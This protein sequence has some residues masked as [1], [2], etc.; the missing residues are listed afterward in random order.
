MSKYTTELRYIVEQALDDV[1][2]S[3]TE[4]NWP[5]CYAA[6]GLDDYPIFDETH[7]AI[8]NNK[9]IRHYYMREIGAETSGRF[10]L[11]VRDAMH[12]I[13]PYYNQLYESEL[14][15][16]ELKPLSDKGVKNTEHSWGTASNSGE[17][18]SESS[19]NQQNVYQ[20]T[21]QSEMIP[22]QIKGLQYATNVTLDED[23]AKAAGKSS[24]SGE[25]D[26]MVERTEIGYTRSQSG[27]LRE[28]RETFLNIDNMVVN[29]RELSQCFMCIW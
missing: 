24:S 19:G 29:D 16:K 27:L 6:V 26:N 3:H 17:N 15:A 18:S 14:I 7:R 9:I 8:L 20:D 12:L 23:S 5:L 22:S 25:Y 2:A 28:Y 4:E 21:P 1:G 13:M 11:F 10:R